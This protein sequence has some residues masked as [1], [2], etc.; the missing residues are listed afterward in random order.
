MLGTAFACICLARHRER[1]AQREH[2]LQEQQRR[3]QEYREHQEQPQKPAAI[4]LTI[5]DI[6]DEYMPIQK[7]GSI[8][9]NYNQSR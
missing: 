9:Q 7:F 5:K 1:E 8:S 2:Q 6:V 3:Q 4:V